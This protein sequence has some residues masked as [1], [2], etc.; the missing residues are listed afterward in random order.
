MGRTVYM[1]LP[2]DETTSMFNR[3]FRR[4]SERRIGD[5]FGAVTEGVEP[6]FNPA[7]LTGVDALL[8][9]TGRTPMTLSV[10]ERDLTIGGADK[11]SHMAKHIW[12]TMSPGSVFFR[13]PSVKDIDAAMKPVGKS[14]GLTLPSDVVSKLSSA[15]DWPFLQTMVRLGMVTASS[16]GHDE[17]IQRHT[18]DIRSVTAKFDKISDQAIRAL[19]ESD[20]E[21]FKALLSQMTNLVDDRPERAM[22]LE[23]TLNNMSNKLQNVIVGANTPRDVVKFSKLMLSEQIGVLRARGLL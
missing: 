18:A 11:W 20:Q 1:R 6:A 13:I 23:R 15:L 16:R 5:L 3:I 14:Q 10:P 22:A 4:V 8:M 19:T 21:Q 17:T 12:N 2:L 7:I 9:A